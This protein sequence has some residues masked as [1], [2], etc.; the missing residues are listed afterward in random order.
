MIV[1]TRVAVAVQ[2]VTDLKRAPPRPRLLTLRR[3]TNPVTGSTDI[4]DTIQTAH[5][6]FRNRLQTKRGPEGKRRIIDY[7]VLDFD[8]TYFPNANRDNFGKPFGQ[9][10]YNYEWYL[11]DRT[12]F[13]SYGWF[14]FWKVQG[15]TIT[16]SN[17]RHTND[18]F[19]LNVITSGF[20]ISRPPR[21]NVFIGYSIINTGPIDTSALNFSYTYWLSPKW[22][23]YVATSYDF[24]NAI[25]LGTTFSVTKITK[26]YLTSV[27]LTV[28]PQRSNYTFAFE[29]SPRFSPNVRFGSTAGQRFDSRFAPAQ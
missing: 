24:G 4:Q 18:P 21:G 2:P 26:D 28:D 17:P 23:M 8:S 6:S 29:I 27:G 3:I 9:N 16:A 7:M 14:E 12:S 19:G 1:Q 25:L 10:T 5:F 11:G 15:Q 13:V 22:Y 20:S